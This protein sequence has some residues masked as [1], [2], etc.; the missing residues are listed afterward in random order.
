MANNMAQIFIFVS[1]LIVKILN[2]WIFVHKIIVLMLKDNYHNKFCT[3][4]Y[5]SNIRF[6]I[7]A[8]LI[9]ISIFQWHVKNSINI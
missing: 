9:I 6:I 3:Q 5:E 2:K 8:I 4:L 1:N 7:L